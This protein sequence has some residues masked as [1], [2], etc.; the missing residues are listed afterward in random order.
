MD[1]VSPSVGGGDTEGVAMLT[2]MTRE[3]WEQ[4]PINASDIRNCLAYGLIDI[5]EA[6]WMHELLVLGEVL[7]DVSVRSLVE[8]YRGDQ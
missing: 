7:D 5:D 1:L 4:T 3:F 6:F 8:I 2:E